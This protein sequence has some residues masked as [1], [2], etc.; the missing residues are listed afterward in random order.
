MNPEDIATFDAA[1]GSR[2]YAGSGIPLKLRSNAADSYRVD[3]ASI[4]ALVDGTVFGSGK[5]GFI[6]TGEALM[7]KEAFQPAG[8]IPW[9]QVRT[10]QVEGDAVFVNGRKVGSY[11]LCERHELA[12]FVAHV[13]GVCLSAGALPAVA[14][15]SSFG[16]DSQAGSP[17]APRTGFAGRVSLPSDFRLGVLLKDHPPPTGELARKL[18][19]VAQL[20]SEIED[21]F[22]A[23]LGEADEVC[24]FMLHQH[25]QLMNSYLPFLLQGE[26]IRSV[27]EMAASAV[28][29]TFVLCIQSTSR[30]PRSFINGL[31]ADGYHQLAGI[32]LGYA[33]FGS[34]LLH[35]RYGTEKLDEAIAVYAGV[36]GNPEYEKPLIALNRSREDVLWE[37]LA[38]SGMSE[39]PLR[40]LR[41][42]SAGI[43]D[44]FL[45]LMLKHMLEDED[46]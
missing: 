5:D 15:A 30:L 16:A 13:A 45:Q 25:V 34:N 40:L 37:G 7:V 32:P 10:L 43:L 23:D 19:A 24:T 44:A 28:F 22:F 36:Y 35:E 6:V 33:Q 2:I 27:P 1:R 46:A 8:G 4:M 21:A 14:P 3:P 26:F 31:G 9:S 39:A 42:Q 11:P 38:R 12:R 17:G 18:L 41:D 20:T 29:M